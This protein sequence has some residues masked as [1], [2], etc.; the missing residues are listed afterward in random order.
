MQS[1]KQKF[2]QQT[3]GKHQL[4]RRMMKFVHEDRFDYKENGE[5]VWGI[6][7]IPAFDKPRPDSI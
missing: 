2:F 1:R 7:A 3:L 4:R 6:Q 5:G